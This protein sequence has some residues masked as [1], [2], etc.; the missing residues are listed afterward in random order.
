ML[1]WQGVGAAVFSQIL[2]EATARITGE[3][4]TGCPELNCEDGT[5]PSGNV[6]YVCCKHF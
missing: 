3:D 5:R 1:F 2:L 4:I 6:F